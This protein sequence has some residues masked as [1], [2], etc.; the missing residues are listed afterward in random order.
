MK[1]KY[2]YALLAI[3]LMSALLIG[4]SST[5]S[6][7]AAEEAAPAEEAAAPAEAEEEVYIAVISKGFQHQF[8]QA[9]AAGAEQAAEDYGVTITFEG[10]ETEAMVD[11]QVEMVQAAMDKKTGRA[12]LSC[13]RYTGTAATARKGTGRR[14]PRR[15][16]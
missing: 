15:W 11:K 13:L 6:E 1:S 4:C 5:A 7:P 9:V 2:L 3:L 10:P 14:H 16:F 12:G 8:W